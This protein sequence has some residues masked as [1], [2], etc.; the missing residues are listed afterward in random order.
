MALGN[1]KMKKPNL[2]INTVLWG[3]MNWQVYYRLILRHV[4]Y[5][6][7]TLML[8]ILKKIDLYLEMWNLSRPSHWDISEKVTNNGKLCLNWT[9]LVM[10]RLKKFAQSHWDQIHKD[11]LK[12]LQISKACWVSFS[13]YKQ[14]LI[15]LSLGDTR[16]KLKLSSKMIL[17]NFS[18]NKQ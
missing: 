5:H 16:Q 6:W 10:R 1:W 7:D 15:Y 17:T 18:V 12:K 3:L 11:M 2:H 8:H 9:S 14:V 13:F 4:Y